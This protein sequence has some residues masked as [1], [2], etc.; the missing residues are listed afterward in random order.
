ML[1]IQSAIRNPQSAIWVLVV[2]LLP[3]MRA[4]ADDRE[5]ALEVLDTA[6]KAQGGAE[7]LTKAAICQRT[8]KGTQFLFGKENPFTAEC[9]MHLPERYHDS[10]VQTIADQR[11][12]II[13]V[14]DGKRGWQTTGGMSMQLVEDRV[15]ELQEELYTMWAMTLVPLK[16]KSVTLSLLPD[17]K[18]A[19]KATTVVKV[20]SKDRPELKLSFD[21]ASGL[22]VKVERKAR[23]AGQQ[24]QKEYWLMDY[25][26]FDRV[27]LPSRG[28]DLLN[29]NKQVEWKV[30][31]YRFPEKIDGSV[32]AKP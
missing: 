20:V 4:Y 2:A 5:K 29:G 24:F 19:G 16:D 8:I 32:F 13:V 25:K 3:A 9:S 14:V 22:L 7:A 21:K 23:L 27:K 1:S 26:A 10:I 31:S 11:T 15:G 12:Q 30:E 17:G 6:I 28:I 18:F